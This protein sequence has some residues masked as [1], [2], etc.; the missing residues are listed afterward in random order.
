MRTPLLP[1]DVARKLYAPDWQSRLKELFESRHDLRLAIRIASPSLA[2][3]LRKWLSGDAISARAQR[4]L[5]AYALRASTRTTPYGLFAAISRVDVGDKTTLEV[6]AEIHTRTRVD[7]GWLAEII[8]QWRENREFRN[9]VQVATND[10]MLRRG[11]RYTSYHPLHTRHGEDQIAYTPITFTATEAVRFLESVMDAPMTLPALATR[12]GERYGEPPDE[13]F[14]LLDELWRA[15]FFIDELGIDPGVADPS[16]EVLARIEAREPGR[17]AKVAAVIDALAAIDARSISSRKEEDYDAADALQIE[18]LE[19]AKNGSQTDAVR[20]CSGAMSAA[21]L[22]D[23]QMMARLMLHGPS[24]SLQEYRKRFEE[25]YEGGTREVPLLEL[26][27]PSFGLGPPEPPRHDPLPKDLFERQTLAAA[28]AMREDQRE[29]VLD[30]NA[31]DVLLPKLEEPRLAESFDLG[32]EVLSSS[33]DA[34]DR[35]EYFIASSGFTFAWRAGA[36]LG[37]FA[38]MLGSGAQSDLQQ[39]AAQLEALH[40]DAIVAELVASPTWARG[41]NVSIRPVKHAHRVRVGLLSDESA[42][43]T[44]ALND[45]V[46]GLDSVGFY[47]RSLRHRKRV[48]LM[49][50]HVLNIAGT[51]PSIARLLSLLARDGIVY[52]HQYLWDARIP[53]LPRI[54]CGRV[55][56]RR[57]SWRFP[58][59]A[60]MEAAA[61]AFHAFIERWGIPRYVELI[62]RDNRLLID[63]ESDL[64][65]MMLQDHVTAERDVVVFEEVL[66]PD[67]HS[68]L[69]EHDG[70]AHYRAEFIASFIRARPIL[71][72]AADGA[73]IAREERLSSPGGDWLYF[74]AYGDAHD[75]DRVLAGRI[76]PVI[77][78]LSAKGSIEQWYFLRYSDPRHHLRVRIRIASGARSEVRAAIDDL[79]EELTREAAV[80][81]SVIATYERE[82]ERYGGAAGMRACEGFFAADSAYVLK[83]VVNA[84]M[85]D[86]DER[87]AFVAQSI[88]EMALECA[89]AS[90]SFDPRGF[91]WKRSSLGEADRESARKIKRQIGNAQLI[92]PEMRIAMREI[93]ALSAGGNLSRTFLSVFDSLLHMHANRCGLSDVL[94]QR[95][96]TLARQVLQGLDHMRA[97]R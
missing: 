35:G 7:M 72:Y 21:L 64:A 40:P 34:L 42:E 76:A 56:L 8:A 73:L 88:V 43:N 55:I 53:F 58:R 94:E 59:Q 28:Q 45:L 31:L 74:K 77:Q 32:F 86:P 68:W 62:D 52:P 66:F 71:R 37:R 20:A 1:Y 41:L 12:L 82:V 79:L 26:V 23:V 81:T 25:R 6:E 60:V 91:T 80:D 39:I 57:A 33:Y 3:E 44:V 51:A 5:L 47:L 27:H 85:S 70:S 10:A 4:R 84:Q 78:S 63:M 9:K 46:V 93:A 61:G 87:V 18:V 54:R 14:R 22:D 96:R 17:T 2:R 89:E 15:G 11:E 97:T 24:W 65:P 90:A 92:S 95:A 16:Q 38:D 13:C 67:Q 75:N 69:K 30:P 50:S 48:I 83:H 29:I 49:E 19:A 36:G